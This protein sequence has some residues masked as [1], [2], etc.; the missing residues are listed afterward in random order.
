M[1]VLAIK[2]AFY[3]EKSIELPSGKTEGKLNARMKHV[4]IATLCFPSR[5]LRLCAS[6]CGF[7]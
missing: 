7:L 3:P 5:P 4:P 1:W 2:P 6:N